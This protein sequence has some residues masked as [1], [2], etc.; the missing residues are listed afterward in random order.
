MLL[1]ED[2]WR[3][4]RSHAA[5]SKSLVAIV[6]YLGRHPREILR[7]PKR[8][9]VICDLSRD[10]VAR[11]A[12]SARGAREL[13]AKG[14]RLYSVRNLHAKIYIF[15]KCAI[16][17]SANLSENSA[18]L[19]EA[20]VLISDDRELATLREYARQLE[21][22]A[23]PHNDDAL[24]ASL[25]KLEPRRLIVSLG[26]RPPRAR[27]APV[28]FFETDPV[29]IWTALWDKEETAAELAA[30]KTRGTELAKHEG[31]KND[32]VQWLNALSRRAKDV[33]E[34]YHHVVFWWPKR[35]RATKAIYGWLEGPWQS[36]GGVDLGAR[37][38]KRR[39]C[40][41]GIERGSKIIPIGRRNI[42]ALARILGM[43]V[44]H[45]P[46]EL[47]RTLD[48]RKTPLRLT[49]D[50]IRRLSAFLKDRPRP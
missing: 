49:A 20:G 36:I 45:D 16:V 43:R 9:T 47:W 25:A 17:A 42:G 31:L 33:I 48:K 4:I 5:R 40:L 39:Y 21:A 35:G 10:T 28:P 11:G 23:H 37:F 29:W 1:G 26:T 15:D 38:G 27:V 13:H 22:T 3:G 50:K 7:W 24:L 44:P 12:S 2:L 14:I 34:P 32:A 19:V 8:S 41:A 30:K 18:R 46:T 6:S